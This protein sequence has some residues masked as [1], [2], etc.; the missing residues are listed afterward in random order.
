MS[1]IKQLDSLR[2]NRNRVDI[3]LCTYDRLVIMYSLQ[4]LKL[5]LYYYTTTNTLTHGFYLMPLII[6]LQCWLLSSERAVSNVLVR[7]NKLT[8]SVSMVLHE[9][10]PKSNDIT[11]SSTHSHTHLLPLCVV[12]VW[13]KVVPDARETESLIEPQVSIPSRDNEVGQVTCL[14]KENESQNNALDT[15]T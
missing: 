6:R 9:G 3:F 1:S 2:I 10:A 11:P 7:C 8:G 4:E 15:S 14:P 5:T 13:L 12:S